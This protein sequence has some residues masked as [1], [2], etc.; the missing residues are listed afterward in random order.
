MFSLNS[1]ER[2]FFEAIKTHFSDDSR[3]LVAFSGGCDSL[4]LLS[5]CS[6]AIG[7]ERTVPVYVNHNIR[8]AAEL[9]NEI[10]LNHENCRKLGVNL[11]VRTLDEGKVKVLAAGRGGGI[12][13]AARVLRYEVLEQ[14]RIKNG[15]SL[16]LTAHHRD[17]QIETVV[18]HMRSGSPMTSL[19]GI[20]EYDS[21]RHLLRPLLKLSRKELERYL[22]SNGMEWST[23]S[24]NSDGRFSRNDVRCNVIPIVAGIWPSFEDAVLG[25]GS[26]ARAGCDEEKSIDISGNRVRLE[27]L[28]GRSLIGRVLHVYALWDS[29]FKD[30]ELPMTLL[31]RVLDAVSE[32]RDCNV[33]SNMAV[34]SIYRGSLYLTD[35]SEDSVFEGFE[36][37]VDPA[38]PHTVLLPGNMELRTGSDAEQ[39]LESMEN[40]D[41][42]LRL[43]PE[44]FEGKVRIR[45][46]REGD[47]IRLRGGSRMVL[48][49]LQD[50][51]IMPGNRC[52]VPVLEDGKE[53]CAVFGSVF[54]GRDR[55]CVKFVTSLARNNFPL[56]IVNSIESKG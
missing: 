20:R 2:V 33:G 37:P 5:L 1:T 40:P 50:M 43:D 19:R 52:R 32:G 18:M 47:S 17:D 25:L 44:R 7:R 54:G 23:D 49:L 14:E 38:N 26:Q 8:A 41:L 53:I 4:A 11:I 15:C 10:S 12:E 35:P 9:E 56:Y 46:A 42:A 34:F 48:R 3:F 24:T 51:K 29:L 22:L 16:I 21:A 39:A 36:L 27:D 31:D 6:K 55:I 45:F 28:K 13:D 30:R